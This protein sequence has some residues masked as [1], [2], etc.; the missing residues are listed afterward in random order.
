MINFI[1][2]KRKISPDVFVY[3]NR[4]DRTPKNKGA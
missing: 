3:S 1:Y 2:N 4:F